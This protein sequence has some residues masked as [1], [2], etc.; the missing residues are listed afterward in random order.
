[1]TDW[2][3]TGRNISG[4]VEVYDSPRSAGPRVMGQREMVAWS[5][6][7][8]GVL[9]LVREAGTGVDGSDRDGIGW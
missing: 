8:A 1:M 6:E 5:R 2:S 7:R 3:H 4:E 9:I